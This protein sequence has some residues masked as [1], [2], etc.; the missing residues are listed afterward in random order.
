MVRLHDL[1]RRGPQMPMQA[2]D[3]VTS[4]TVTLPSSG[5][6]LP[7]PAEVVVAEGGAGDDEEPILAEAR[8]GEVALDPAAPVEHLRVGD[9]ADRAVHLVVAQAAAGRRARPAR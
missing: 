3:E 8:D 4:L 7:D 5:A 2:R 9:P 6:W 1:A